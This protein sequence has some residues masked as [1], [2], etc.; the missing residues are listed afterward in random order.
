M[1][2][3][4]IEPFIKKA[5]KKFYAEMKIVR[6]DSK[7]LI[8]YTPSISGL[9]HLLEKDLASSPE[10]RANKG[11]LLCLANGKTESLLAVF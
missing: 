2:G 6:H 10:V 9:R 11:V 3:L 4:L 7:F 5:P 8:N 1:G